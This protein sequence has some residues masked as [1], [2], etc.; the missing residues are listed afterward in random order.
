MFS[1]Y[2]LTQKAIDLL[3][4]VLE[5]APQHTPVL[6]RLLDLSVGA[7]NDRRTA[8]LAATLA[9]IA[10]ERND[11]AAAERHAEFGRRFQ[12]AAGTTQGNSAPQEFA[13]PT[14]E[15]ELD[16]S[17]DKESE[18]QRSVP[19]G[20]PMPVESVVH[21]V[22]LSDEWA[23]LSRQL[24]DAMEQEPQNDSVDTSIAGQAGSPVPAEA[25]AF[26]LEPQN[27]SP[28]DAGESETQ[29]AD[30]LIAD[31]AADLE[32]ATMSMGLPAEMA[33]RAPAQPASPVN[34]PAAYSKSAN[35]GGPAAA[36]PCERHI[37]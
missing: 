6:E 30:N 17:A 7:G 2:G 36:A 15:A 13:V 33:D 37:C 1:S 14:I 10:L 3:E 20:I 34:V 28:A 27:V 5:R 9:Q 21:E 24:E 22:D 31:L 35:G 18:T 19:M 29:A 11:R 4:S 32:S 23:A 12:R 25:P 26:E 8:E 16:E